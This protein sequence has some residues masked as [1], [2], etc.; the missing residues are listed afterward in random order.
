[1]AGLFMRWHTR[2][3]TNIQ[4]NRSGEAFPGDP[5]NWIRTKYER[6]KSAGLVEILLGL[7]KW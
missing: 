6:A 2:G 3:G 1:M 4:K 5:R 7:K